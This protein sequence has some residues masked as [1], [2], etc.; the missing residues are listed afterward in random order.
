MNHDFVQ[1]LFVVLDFNDCTNAC[2]RT[3]L[4]ITY[5]LNPAQA[6][7]KLYLNVCCIAMKTTPVL[8]VHRALHNFCKYII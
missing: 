1:S 8:C 7:L 2:H 6:S 3:V 5:R 4:I